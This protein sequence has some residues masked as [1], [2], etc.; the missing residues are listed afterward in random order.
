LPKFL[1][2]QNFGGGLAPTLPQDRTPLATVTVRWNID[3]L[4][5]TKHC[6]CHYIV[7]HINIALLCHR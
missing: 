3:C 7:Y 6:F 5:L 4:T 2:N 1:T